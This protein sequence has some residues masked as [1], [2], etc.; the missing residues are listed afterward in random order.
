[1]K[2][3]VVGIGHSLRG[4]DA[5]GLEAVSIWKRDYPSTASL[6]A[7]RVELVESP[8][9]ELATLLQG[10]EAVLLVDA[11]RSGAGIGHLHRLIESDIA[12]LIATSGSMHGWG[13]PEALKMAK[14]LGFQSTEGNIVMLGIEAAQTNI[15]APLSTEVRNVMPTA[16]EAIEN[17][18]RALL[19]A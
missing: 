19:T 5:A 4:D 1:M 9:V 6:P 2:V 7:V 13:I 3:L 8:G 15:G 12:A 10:A 14:A 17:E 16:A 11:V 18:I